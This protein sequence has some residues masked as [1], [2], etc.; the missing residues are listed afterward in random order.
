VNCGKGGVD[1]HVAASRLIPTGPLEEYGVEDPRITQ[2]DNRYYVTYVA[3]SRHGAATALASTTD[4]QNFTRH[5]VIFPPENKDVVLFPER[6]R[7]RYCA[8][9]RPTTATPFSTPE[10]WVAWSSDLE[11]WGHHEPIEVAVGRPW[12]SGRVGA[13]VPPLRVAEG[14][15][16]IFHAN[17]RPAEAGQV[18][19]YVAAAMLL[20]ANDPSKVIAQGEAALLT[21]TEPF[22]SSGFVPDVVFPTGMVRRDDTLQIYYGASDTNT[23]FTELSLADTLRDMLRSR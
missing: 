2:I 12:A 15:L 11:R 17:Q 9:H 10:M 22:E 21:P 23:G 3:V 20:D 5:G 14:W 4:F 19:Q 18:G 8:L 16:V 1:K 6:I 13:G 7:G